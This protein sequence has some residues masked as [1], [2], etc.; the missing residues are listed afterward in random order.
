[1][2][3]STATYGPGLKNDLVEPK[4]WKSTPESIKTIVLTHVALAAE[5]HHLYQ[6]CDHLIEQVHTLKSTKTARS[7]K[8]RPSPAVQELYSKLLFKGKKHISELS[9]FPMMFEAVGAE[10]LEK[11]L[12][13]RLAQQYG[14]NIDEVYSN[15][16]PTVVGP[17]WNLEDGLD[18]SDLERATFTRYEKLYRDI[19]VKY[20]SSNDKCILREYKRLTRILGWR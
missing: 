20:L 10:R 4:A 5:I 6:I 18:L 15:P 9:T 16:E 17:E 14:I 3:S 11:A 7:N 19:F 1:M 13:Y 8:F 2:S 12:S